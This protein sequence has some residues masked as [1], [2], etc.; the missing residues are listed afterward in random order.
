MHPSGSKADYDWRLKR[1]DRAMSAG[2]G[3][4]G[5]GALY[6]LYEPD[7]ETLALIYHS[8]YLT[9]TFG[10]AAHTVS[11]P[12]LRPAEG[13]LITESPYSLSDEHFKLTVA[14]LRLALPT[15]GIVLTTRENSRL[16]REFLHCGIS[17]ISAGSSTEPGGY[18]EGKGEEHELSQF[19]IDDTRSIEEVVHRYCQR[20]AFA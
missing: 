4:V 7:F 13:A 11:V 15:T 9:K 14:V 16:R 10:S 3:D 1:Y 2:L 5:I 12:R 6:G 8:Q 17:Q 20:R 19:E 18:T